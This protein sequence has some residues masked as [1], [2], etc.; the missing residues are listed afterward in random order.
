MGRQI[1]Y[2]LA[3][4]IQ[5]GSIGG[6]KLADGAITNAKVS[7]T[8]GI[9]RTKLSGLG[10]GGDGSD[11]A[12]TVSSGTTNIDL[13]GARVVVKN[14]TSISI[15]GTGKVTFTNPHANGTH[16]IFKSQGNVTL[17]SSQAPMIDASGM[18]AIGGAAV[19]RGTA[20]VTNGNAGTDGFGAIWKSNLGNAS[21]NAAIGTGGAVSSSIKTYEELSQILKYP[22]AVPGAGGGSAYVDTGNT[23]STPAGGRGGGSLIIECGGT[24]TFTTAA[25]ISVAGVSPGA[26]ANAS[27]SSGGSGGGGGGYF[28]AL[29]NTLG[30]STGTVTISGGTGGNCA[31]VSGAASFG[32]GGG[33]SG[34]TAG[35]NGTT[36]TTN[37]TKTGGDGA[38]GFSSISKNTEY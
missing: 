10:F 29:Y 6:E 32:A 9:A 19:S 21:T 14:Y 1:R 15:T 37:G 33:A 24:W 27:G 28:R 12:L 16:I 5:D 26:S 23:G 31:Y 25:G 20:G 2:G 38:A 11:G 22:D 13:A 17:T 30:S 18:G 3:S 34:K 4:A 8:A 36:S 35:S 7:A